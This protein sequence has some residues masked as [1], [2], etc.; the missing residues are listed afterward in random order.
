MNT[1]R[2]V[3]STGSRL[4]VNYNL[5]QVITSEKLSLLERA[6]FRST[7][8]RDLSRDLALISLSCSILY[9]VSCLEYH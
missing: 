1:N 4:T 3:L 6:S 8:T 2:S 9:G 5:N 7:P